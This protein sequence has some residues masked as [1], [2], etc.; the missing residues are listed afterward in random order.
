MISACTYA[1]FRGEPAKLMINSEIKMGS[2]RLHRLTSEAGSACLFNAGLN[3]T[4]GYRIGTVARLTGLSTDTIR[5]WERRYC[6]VEPNR[7]DNNNRFYTD[8]HVRKLIS[9]KRLVDAGQAIGSICRLTDDELS[10][11]TR[12]LTG[13]DRQFA[14]GASNK[15][16]VFSIQQSA[17]LKACLKVHP[18]HLVCWYKELSAIDLADHDCIVIDMP[19]LSELHEQEIMSCVSDELSARCLIVYRYAARTQLRNLATRGFRLLKGPL[20]PFALVNL[21][22]G[23]NQPF[24]VVEPRRFDAEQLGKLAEFSGNVCKPPRRLP[25]LVVA[26]NQFEDDANECLTQGEDDSELYR[27]IFN[28][29]HQAR[30]LMEQALSEV[31]EAQDCEG[32]KNQSSG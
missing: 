5:A 25:E 3:E 19:S 28:F 32:K 30:C 22:G 7:S 6:V 11:R 29:A 9:V 18:D 4:F 24:S 8:A 15:W 17:W 31:V 20:E 2:G 14:V 21:L 23:E 26:L 10:R 27:R 16:A 1:A 13:I 12:R